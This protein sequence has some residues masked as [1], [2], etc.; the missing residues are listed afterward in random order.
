MT[1][2]TMKLWRVSV[3]CVVTVLVTACGGGG[4]SSPPPVTTYNVNTTAGSQGSF[5]PASATVNAASTTTFTITPNSGYVISSVTGC[6]GS[7]SGSTYTTGAVSANCTVTASFSAAF[8]WVSGPMTSD[9]SA[10]YGTQGVGSTSNTP[11]GRRGPVSWSDASGNLWLFGGYGVGSSI[12]N[13]L[14]EYS[15]ASGQWTWVSGPNMPDAAGV[16]GTLG[17]PAST[18]TPGAL[19]ASA[20]SWTDAGGNVWL[21]GGYGYDSAGNRGW[22]N[23]LWEYSPTSGKWT[24]SAGST[25]NAALGVYG[26]E[27]VVAATNYPSSRAVGGW[28]DSTGTVWL[29]GGYGYDSTGAL[30][31]LNDLWSYSLSSHEW[32]WVSGSNTVNVKGVYGTQGTAASTNVPGA[33]SGY[34]TWTDAGGDLWLFGGYGYDSAG[35]QGSLNDL[36]KYS[37]A[38]NQ[39]TWVAG[40]NTVN[41][42]GVYGTLGTAAAANLPGARYSTA[43]WTDS[44][45]N[46]WLFSGTGYDSAGASNELN[47]LWKYSPSSNQWTWVAGSNTVNATGVYGAQGAAAAANVPG[48]RDGVTALTDGKF[49]WLFAGEGLNISGADP[50]APQWSDLWKYPIQ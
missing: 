6:G 36:W 48:A 27:G 15:T 24:W 29:F 31:R 26:T 3:P 42:A 17:T 8:T 46:L 7:L 13:D 19:A 9:A 39:W 1:I 23:A 47:D 28:K 2:G 44:A 37:P 16:F 33:R 25:T 34:A 14:W 4:S 22:L 43:A 21:F 35:T 49:V 20:F 40:S 11:G 5:S 45:G 38:S 41:A 32:T 12:Y 50:T 30:G 18:N 10:V